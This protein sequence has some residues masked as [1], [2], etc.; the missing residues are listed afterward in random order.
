MR[1]PI[2]RCWD[3]SISFYRMESPIGPL[4][5]SGFDWRYLQLKIATG[6]RPLHLDAFHVNYTA[7]PFVSRATFTSSDPALEDLADLLADCE[8]RCS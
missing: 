5:H 7:F 6:D 8:T 4:L 3:S 1:S 2:A